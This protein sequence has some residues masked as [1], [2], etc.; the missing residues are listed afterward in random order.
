MKKVE[1]GDVLRVDGIPH[2]LIVVSQDFFNDSGNAIVCPIVPDATKSPLHISFKTP[3]ISGIVLC[4]QVRLVSLAHRHYVRL[5]SARLFEM[6]D[7]TD[8]V[9]G[10]FDY[11]KS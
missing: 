4:E 6:M 5:S 8:A 3:A 2:P 11:Q 7:I 9:M 10:I 1:Q